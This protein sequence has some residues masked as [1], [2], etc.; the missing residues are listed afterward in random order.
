MRVAILGTGTMGAGMARSMQR[1]GLDV[2]AWNRTASK[3]EPL[4]ADGITVSASVT[5]AVRGA[6]AVLTM[7]FDA[8][9]VL[10]V[11]DDLLDGLGDGA[12]WVQSA[13]VGVEGIQ[14]IAERA[15]DVALLDAPML[16]T[17]EPAEQGKLVPLVSGDSA[18]VERIRPVLDAV[19]TKT[20]V[21]GERIGDA[22]ALKLSCNAWI[23]SITAATAQSLAL[24]DRLGVE[25]SLFLEAIDGGPSNTPYAQLKGKAML[26]GNFNP[27]FG[28]DGGRKDLGLI[29]DAATSAGVDRALLDGVRALYDTASANGHGEDDLAAV[30]TA[31]SQR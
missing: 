6:D 14:R 5:E 16:G 17:K 27:S 15:G 13:T 2:S 25:A 11:A 1:A 10:A 7:L 18:L 20:V 9:A 12:I 3:A 29:A 28:L 19:G 4:A 21:A 23:L 8:D 22:T 31:L 24:A 26:G 30:Y